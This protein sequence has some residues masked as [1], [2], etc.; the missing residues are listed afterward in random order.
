MLSDIE[1]GDI[2][3]GQVPTTEKGGT[4]GTQVDEV[5]AL[6]AFAGKVSEVSESLK[7]SLL[8]IKT[9]F[10]MLKSNQVELTQEE[11]NKIYDSVLENLSET[12][13]AI[14]KL[15]E[16]KQD[17][18]LDTGEIKADEEET[19]RAFADRVA[20]EIHD[21][22]NPLGAVSMACETIKFHYEKLNQE[23]K[24]EIYDVVLTALDTAIEI[25]NKLLG[26]D[27]PGHDTE[28]MKNISQV[29]VSELVE[30]IIAECKIEFPE[31]NITIEKD[32][33]LGSVK[34]EKV[35]L[36][37]LFQNLI[38]NDI[39]Y[40]DSENPEIRISYKYEEGE[41]GEHHYTIKDNGT[42]IPSDIINNLFEP[43]VRG[44]KG[45]GQG[46]GLSTVK[47]I[48]EAHNGTI[49]VTNDNGACFE[50]TLRDIV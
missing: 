42:G 31:K 27:T 13:E 18:D 4:D 21:I 35:Q 30:K 12:L 9:K 38:V 28:V 23:D 26:K 5:G 15:S 45:K 32:S 43:G 14:A 2:N 20:R 3:L 22:R 33:D 40:I 37:R 36:N 41:E 29:D 6:E 34:S 46:L 24:D 49:S 7:N 8:D 17:K 39:K 50:F 1:G 44:K 47:K 11:E 48:V 10:E 16:P 25:N 19:F